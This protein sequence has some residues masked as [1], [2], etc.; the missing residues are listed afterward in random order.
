LTYIEYLILL[1][2]EY[3]LNANK[4]FMESMNKNIS[5]LKEMLEKRET[6]IRFSPAWTMIMWVMYILLYILGWNLNDNYYTL[7]FFSIWTIWVI[8][9]T[10]FSLLNSKNKGEQLLP[11]SIRY[12]VVNMF[13]IGIA[14]SPLLFLFS[15]ME[16]S[17]SNILP[18]VCVAYWLLM[19]V[20]R[21][22][23]QK[24][25]SH[26]G[27]MNF[28]I[29]MSIVWILMFVNPNSYL[30]EITLWYNEY[31]KE[32]ILVLFWFGHVLMW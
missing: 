19:I 23:I 8:L 4:Y 11:K 15:L 7:I 1:I 5:A 21:F 31:Y 2:T 30:Y 20:S 16:S 25:L 3:F 24:F 29:G 14:V 12:I 27:Y 28:V 32:L 13:F 10:L 6:Y 18:I 17:M 9:V 26:F 22:C